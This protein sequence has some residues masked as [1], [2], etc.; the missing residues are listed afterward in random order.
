MTDT[1]IRVDNLSKLYHIGMLQ[2]RHDTPATALRAGLRDALTARF[3]S[4]PKSKTQNPK[5]H[6]LRVLKDVSL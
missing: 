4:N 1:A 2:H 6:K 3:R 5:S